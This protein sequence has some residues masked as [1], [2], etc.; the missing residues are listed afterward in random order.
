MEK[1]DLVAFSIDTF[2]QKLHHIKH[3]FL[4]EI[5]NLIV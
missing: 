1:K 4:V 3:T 5:V 2:A